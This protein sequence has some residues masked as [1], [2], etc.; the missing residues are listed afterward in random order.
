MRASRVGDQFYG[1]FK[2]TLWE[3]TRFC[4]VCDLRVGEF[5]SHVDS[6]DRVLAGRYQWLGNGTINTVFGKH[7]WDKQDCQTLR[8]AAL[9][10]VVAV[11]TVLLPD[12]STVLQG[13][14]FLE[15]V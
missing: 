2:Q 8:V 6:R 3:V 12:G 5:F 13:Q 1:D 9:E 15:N 7:Q 11:D 4:R 14:I 10:Q